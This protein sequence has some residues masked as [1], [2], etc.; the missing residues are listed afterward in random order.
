MHISVISASSVGIISQ[1][2]NISLRTSSMHTIYLKK[3]SCSGKYNINKF[4]YYV[5]IR[6]LTSGCESLQAI[7]LKK[8]YLGNKLFLFNLHINTYHH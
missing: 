3:R 5:D 1:E 7:K 6:F 2:E 8:N 4:K